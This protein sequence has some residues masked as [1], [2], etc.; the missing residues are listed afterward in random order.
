VNKKLR[1]AAFFAAALAVVTAAACRGTQNIPVFDT[2]IVFINNLFHFPFTEKLY[3]QIDPS[4]A[5]IVWKIRFPR[6][7]L[8]FLA[9]GS[10]SV[11]GAVFQ[12]A[13]KN[14]LASPYMLG[15][16]SGASL[17]AGTVMLLGFSFNLAASWAAPAAGFVC[18]LASVF[19]VTAFSAKIDKSFSNNTVILC[20]MVFSLFINAIITIM[21][22]FNSDK[23]R[24]LIIWQMG[25]FAYKSWNE[26]M[27]MF[28]FLIIGVCA[29]S[30]Y[31]K[32]MDIMTFGETEAAS[33]GVDAPKIKTILFLFSTVLSGAAVALSGIIG[34]VDLIGPHIARRITGSLHAYVLPASFAAGGILMVLSDLI[35]RTIISPLELPVGAVTALIGAPFFAYIY[36][37]KK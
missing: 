31:V 5:A 9:G 27:M 6:V 34:F 22:A 25:S 7:L 17:G 3:Q 24:A 30:R 21:A 18:G 11:S 1:I 26:T 28:V 4:T 10:V 37:K 35:A 2:F 20:G 15:V 33:A 13:L 16:S 23:I 32:E 14:P 8:A 12:S 29:L 36:F 19:A